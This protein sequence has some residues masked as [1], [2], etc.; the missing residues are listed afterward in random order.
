VETPRSANGIYINSKENF[1]IRS[2]ETT[3]PTLSTVTMERDK[4]VKRTK[5]RTHESTNE[6]WSGDDDEFQS[7]SYPH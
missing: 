5:Q 1:N 3:K 6:D 4:L 2:N 7:S